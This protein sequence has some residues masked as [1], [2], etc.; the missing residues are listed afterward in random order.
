M[1]APQEFLIIIRQAPF[2]SLL[3]AAALDI[4]LT[5]AAFEQKVTLLFSGDGV[6]HLIPDQQAKGTGMKNISQ[7]LPVLE[8]YD[9]KNIL[10]D[11]DALLKRNVRLQDLLMKAEAVS[12]NKI[13]KI[14]EKADQLFNF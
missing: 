9:V 11:G 2:S 14:C 10:V 12:L 8:L 1:I 13:A 3:P 6:L 5:A 4:L 7:A